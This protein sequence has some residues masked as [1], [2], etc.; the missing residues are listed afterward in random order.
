[1]IANVLG[2]AVYPNKFPEIGWFSI[3]LTSEGTKSS[4]F[5]GFPSTFEAFSWHGDTFDLPSG[6]NRLATSEAC[7]NQ[8]FN[9]RG[10]VL[11][12]Q[13]HLEPLRTGIQQFV[14][15][16]SSQ[17]VEGK[18]IQT[19]EILLSKGHLIHMHSL[20]TLLL[21]NLEKSYAGV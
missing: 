9:F 20:M 18:Y 19:K 5:R 4:A 6:C 12:L 17:L 10:H 3:S 21:N 16:S 8:A 13:F 1:L 7:E 2:A 14:A 15:N 11:G